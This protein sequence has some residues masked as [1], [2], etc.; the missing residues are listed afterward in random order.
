MCGDAELVGD[1]TE[2]LR[3]SDLHIP[4]YNDGVCVESYHGFVCQCEPQ[5]DGQRCQNTKV[6]ISNN[7]YAWFPT[8]GKLS[9]RAC[10][11]LI[12]FLLFESS[13]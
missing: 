12:K 1:G 13:F 5:Y 11:Y 10:M 4:C 3:C 2:P 6:S 9:P 7:A 8:I